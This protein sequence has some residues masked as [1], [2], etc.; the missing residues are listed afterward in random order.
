MND[1]IT[2]R[3]RF[4]VAAMTLSACASGTF[5]PSILRV[6]SAW[7]ES[8]DNL[9]QETMAAMVRM[10]R[11]L[12][13]HNAMSDEFYGDLL[14]AVLSG[15]AGD[16]SFAA[17]LN[18]A[19]RALNDARPGDW[20]DLDESEQLAV[21]REVQDQGFFG[22]ITGNVRAGIYLSPVFWKHINYPGSSKEF[23]GYIN[24]GSGDIDWL[25]EG[26]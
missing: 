1:K 3:R 23:G 11:I 6:S 9:D 17:I 7:A 16:Q 21:M 14:N 20:F 19:E 4:L 12:F 22:A 24:R 25:P 18:A 13:P 26:S 5:G 10:A 2:T 15:T 8:Q